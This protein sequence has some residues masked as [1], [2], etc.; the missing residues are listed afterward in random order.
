LKKLDSGFARNTAKKE[1]FSKR[2]E[3]I[4]NIQGKP[5]QHSSSI[6]SSYRSRLQKS[7]VL[8]NN[9]NLCFL[10]IGLI[11]KRSQKAGACKEES[12]EMGAEN[13][14]KKL[15]PQGEIYR[16]PS[17]GYED[18]F[19]VSF[20]FEPKSSSAEVFLICPNCHSRFRLGW[21]I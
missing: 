12:M 3:I 5:G 6:K 7:T 4:S 18:G 15:E 10:K 1:F 9:K 21:K 11:I 20:R 14:I 17:C 19:H 16:C 13:K 8:A 2:L